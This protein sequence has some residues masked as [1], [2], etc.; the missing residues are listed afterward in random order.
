MRSVSSRLG[1]KQPMLFL[2]AEHTI[3]DL[4]LAFSRSKRRVNGLEGYD[5]VCAVC[6]SLDGR[7][8]SCRAIEML[9][10]ALVA[11]T[12]VTAS[13]GA[14][15]STEFAIDL[16]R[17]RSPRSFCDVT[18]DL[19]ASGREKVG[20][21]RSRFLMAFFTRKTGA[22]NSRKNSGSYLHWAESKSDF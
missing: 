12:F 22:K 19:T 4:L 17:D 6:S 9:G 2:T 21:G 16:Y 3:R 8:V 10:R 20:G 7:S 13:L 18:S 15:F 5:A 11:Q 1:C 14:V